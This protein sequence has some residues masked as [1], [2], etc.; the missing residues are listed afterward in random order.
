MGSFTKIDLL[1]DR[2]VI[3]P[4]GWHKL[5]SLRRKIEVP[6]A[7]VVSVAQDHRLA[8]N[9]PNG[10]RLPGTSIPGVYIA[11]SFWRFWGNDRMWSFW[12]RRHAENCITFRLRNN[13]FTI[14]TV[15]VENPTQEVA[16]ITEHMREYGFVLG[17]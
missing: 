8:E 11:G 13:H 9:G 12:I 1:G 5:W 4:V 7:D 16:T 17:A 3:E 2:L 6:F 10:M 14:I 15:E